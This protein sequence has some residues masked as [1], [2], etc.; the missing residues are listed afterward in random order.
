MDADQEV[1]RGMA[2]IGKVISLEEGYRHTWPYNLMYATFTPKDEG[3]WN[4]VFSV[5][6]PGFLESLK[7]LTERERKVIDYRFRQ[8]MTLRETG[9]QF[10]VQAER[11]R[12]VEARAIR[13]MRHPRSWGKWKMVQEQELLEARGESSG[14]L[15]ENITLRNKLQKIAEIIGTDY[16]PV[17]EQEETKEPEE[18]SR[19]DTPLDEMGLSVRAYNCCRGVGLYTVGDFVGMTTDDLMKVRNLG[20]KCMDEIVSR[21]KDYGVVI[22]NA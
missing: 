5:Y 10:G 14:L 17:K 13:K 19:L 18:P 6:V 2:N 20:R 22:E 16:L 9:E 7:D 8:G 4:H 15:L 21:L 3:G 11:I 1:G 12:Q